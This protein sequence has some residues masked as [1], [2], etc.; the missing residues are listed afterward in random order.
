[1]EPLTT[2][3]RSARSRVFWS[4]S[5]CLLR[6]PP[7]TP[8]W[9]SHGMRDLLAASFAPIKP[10]RHPRTAGRATLGASDKKGDDGRHRDASRRCS[11]ESVQ[12]GEGVLVAAV[13][14]SDQGDA[15]ASRASECC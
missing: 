4:P 1:P 13:T 11:Y 8:H 2:L 12:G 10:S 3:P 5:R 15:R 7:P 14:A 6:G 9:D